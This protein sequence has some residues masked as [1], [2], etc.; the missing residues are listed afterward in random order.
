MFSGQDNEELLI[1]NQEQRMFD[2]I[3]ERCMDI[4]PLL[5]SSQYCNF[6]DNQLDYEEVLRTHTAGYN[7]EQ[8]F[9]NEFGFLQDLNQD[10]EKDEVNY[11][12]YEPDP[13]PDLDVNEPETANEIFTNAPSKSSIQPYLNTTSR[14][15]FNSN[16]VGEFYKFRNNRR[17]SSRHRDAHVGTAAHGCTQ[18]SSTSENAM[19]STVI[20]IST[21]KLKS[22]LKL[23]DFVQGLNQET[24]SAL[25]KFPSE[26]QPYSDCVPRNYWSSGLELVALVTKIISLR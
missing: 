24:P 1:S 11:Y 25:S 4:G 21:V 5:S 16:W 15:P 13:L 18:G 6:S 8:N 10:L 2:N 12:N 19:N 3:H 20:N 17:T 9:E 26:Y 7:F 22:P 23:G 14:G